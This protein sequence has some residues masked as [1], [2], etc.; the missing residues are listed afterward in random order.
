MIESVE[1]AKNQ[2]VWSSLLKPFKNQV[3]IT[4]SIKVC[5]VICN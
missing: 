5:A 2:K 4:E 1:L 3:R